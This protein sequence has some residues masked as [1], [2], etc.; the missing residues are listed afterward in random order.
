MKEFGISGAKGCH[1][2]PVQD[3]L[4]P[5]PSNNSMGRQGKSGNASEAIRRGRAYHGTYT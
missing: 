4:D 1:S 2:W 3:R 5:W